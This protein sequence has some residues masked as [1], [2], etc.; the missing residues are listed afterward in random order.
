M[1]QDT[2]TEH[3]QRT[4]SSTIVENREEE[5]FQVIPPSIDGLPACI[6]DV[7]QA[8][9]DGD[10]GTADP[11]EFNQLRGRLETA[12][13]KLPPLYR[14]TVFTPYVQ[15]LNELGPTGFNQVLLQDPARERAA[16]LI[17][18][19]AHAILQNGEGFN[20]RQ[21]DAFQ[22][23][24]SDLYDG[25]LS[26][27]DRIG[28]E[29]P[30]L[31]VVPPLVKW[32]RPDFGPYTFPI[33][34][35]SSFGCGA[36][37]VSLPPGNARRGLLAWASLAHET[38]GHD[39]LSA[40]TGLRGQLIQA[41]FAA[42]QARNMDSL[43]NYWASRID[44]TAADIMG[45]LNMGPAA[46]IGLVGYFRGL[47]AAFTGEARLR[48]LGPATDPHPADI[49]R[50]FLA[51]STVRLLQFQQADAWGHIIESETRKDVSTI[52]LDGRPVSEAEARD[53]A[54]LV[55]EDDRENPAPSPGKPCTAGYPELARS[56][57]RDHDTV[58][59]RAHHGD[60]VADP[61]RY[62]RFRSARRRGRSHGG[63]G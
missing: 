40:D 46:G 22:E 8:G 6:E 54:Q 60:P 17:L 4:T 31:G 39:I 14:E 34:A 36:A 45:I 20:E 16:G 27:E 10:T 28:V 13:L 1:A 26:A 52:R 18:D 61:V 43:A 33:E 56:G 25:F 21:T 58:T 42:L 12:R 47:N 59:E 55:A 62:R 44:E 32:G 3:P 5:G 51:A 24:V 23:V 2:I 15:T 57:R 53:S 29:Q 9:L 30:D 11:T 48:N 50:G 63:P 19:I 35:T 37:V 7:R 38:A 49:V 41:V